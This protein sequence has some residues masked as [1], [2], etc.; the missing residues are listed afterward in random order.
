MMKT[1]PWPLLGCWVAGLLGDSGGDIE[2]GWGDMSLI[3]GEDWLG[4]SR[5]SG[6][7]YRRDKRE[8]CSSEDVYA[9]ERDTGNKGRMGICSGDIILPPQGHDKERVG[10]WKGFKCKFRIVRVRESATPTAAVI[11]SIPA[12]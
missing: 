11:S 7:V 3:P 9:E 8:A 2:R 5:I 4:R 10:A 6:R 12:S 1:V